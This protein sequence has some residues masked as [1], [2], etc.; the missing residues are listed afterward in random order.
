MNLK[1]KTYS[2][3]CV[4]GSNPSGYLKEKSVTERARQQG[5]HGSIVTE[6]VI[7]S[8]TLPLGKELGKTQSSGHSL[9]LVELGPCRKGKNI[10]GKKGT[11]ISD[12]PVQ[13]D[14]SSEGRS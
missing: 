2:S 1:K 9:S 11:S 5:P 7:A 12:K 8:C 13:R 6:L 4:N 10:F 14:D 3:T